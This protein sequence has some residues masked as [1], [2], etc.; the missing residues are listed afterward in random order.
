MRTTLFTV[1]ACVLALS[2]CERDVPEIATVDAFATEGEEAATVDVAAIDTV[3]DLPRHIVVDNDHLKAEINFDEALFAKAPA[4]AMDIVDD[5]Q[6]RLEAM[7]ADALAYQAADPTYFRPYGLRIEWRVVAEAGDVM[8]LEGFTYTFM[9][10]AHGNFFTDARM[11]DSVSG[12]QLRLSSFFN[13]PQEAVRAHLNRVH[14]GIAEQKALKAGSTESLK[15]FTDEAAELVSADMVLAAEVSLVP[16][17]EE[18]K[19]GGYAVHFAPYEI[20][21]YAE[22]AYHV[23]VPQSAFH[24]ELKG[25]YASLFAGKPVSITRPDE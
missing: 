11:Y 4:I 6:V 1:L 14:N 12:Q 18:G 25:E 15:R 7:E 13:E 19:F 5:S 16:S 24:E 10:G 8:S 21:S 22:G 9:A 3:A 23:T 20:G 17:T 2:A